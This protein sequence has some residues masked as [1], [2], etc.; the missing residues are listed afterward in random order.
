MKAE[1]TMLRVM[2]SMTVDASHLVI[3]KPQAQIRELLLKL[4]G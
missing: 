3:P 4:A 2:P 1:L